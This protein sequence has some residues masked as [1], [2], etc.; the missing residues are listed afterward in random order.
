MERKLSI[1]KSGARNGAWR[2][3]ALIILDT[4]KVL[5]LLKM[6]ALVIGLRILARFWPH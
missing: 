4:V 5:V 3:Y 1:L 6:D 2:S